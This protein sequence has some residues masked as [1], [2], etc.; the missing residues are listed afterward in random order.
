MLRN[1]LSRSLLAFTLIELLV[2]VAIIAILA[3]MLLPA[4]A[5]AREKARRS[6][7]MNNLKQT[8][9]GLASYTSDYSDYLP[10][11]NATDDIDRTFSRTAT[12][13]DPDYIHNNKNFGFVTDQRTGQVGL[14]GFGIQKT[15]YWDNAAESGTSSWR[16]IGLF[17][18][19]HNLTAGKFNNFPLGL[20]FL[21]TCNYVADIRNFYCPTADG[22][23][24]GNYKKSYGPIDVPC[25]TGHWRDIGGY[26]SAEFLYGNYRT[27]HKIPIGYPVRYPYGGSTPTNPL[28]GHRNT[29]YNRGVWSYCNYAYRNVPW[30][31]H[32]ARMA[33]YY[34][35]E[36]GNPAGDFYIPEEVAYTRPIVKTHSGRPFFETTK[37]LQ[38]LAIVSDGFSSGSDCDRT[39][40]ETSLPL[41][42]TCRNPGQGPGNWY[43]AALPDC[44]DERWAHQNG[45]NVLYGDGSSAWY[46]DPQ[47]KLTWWPM[48]YPASIRVTSV[49]L[50]SERNVS[51][52]SYDRTYAG[53]HLSGDCWAP[54]S[55]SASSKRTWI[56]PMKRIWH[57][58][59]EAHV[60]DV[61]AWE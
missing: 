1:Y 46:G 22:Q 24:P 50:Y 7:C 27:Y 10:S 49:S 58:L 5:A 18:T 42:G 57:E 31:A 44:A 6:A 13:S 55:G 38:G 48:Q 37:L 47:Q 9:I 33:E 45:V 21:L 36:T 34:G 51:I 16:Q 17:Q 15:D 23:M 14:C 30:F 29:T 2:V 8:A 25:S 39:G 40:S 26:T 56:N 59:D 53:D 19:S 41:F 12:N 28:P 52:P 20:G 32:K 3:A 54:Y 4:L 61:G 43:W 60:L 35:G 11:T